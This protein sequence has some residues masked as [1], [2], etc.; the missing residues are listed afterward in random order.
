MLQ[1]LPP[2]AQLMLE[3]EPVLTN[4]EK[5]ARKAEEFAKA[6]APVKAY[7]GDVHLLSPQTASSR[8]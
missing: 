8:K 3:F 4:K 6:V 5:G 7:S 2:R 1:L